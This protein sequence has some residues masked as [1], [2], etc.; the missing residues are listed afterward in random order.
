MA[1]CQLRL[2]EERKQWR[3][4][5]PFG[6]WARPVKNAQG[7]LDLKVWECGIP[8]K[9]KTMWEGGLFKLTMTFPDEYPT[10]PPKCKFTPPLFHPN[11]Y[12]SGTV[13]LSI[14]NEDEGWKPAITVKQIAL[15]IQDLLDNPNPESPAQA[16]A[17]NLFKRDKHE[18]ERRVRRT[19]KDNPA[20]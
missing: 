8:G 4:D 10:K 17:Y 11:V 14:L 1:L 3:K 9:E 2:G 12:P 7:V 13:C 18:Y 6:F 16:E 19:V 15:G 5:H 20:H